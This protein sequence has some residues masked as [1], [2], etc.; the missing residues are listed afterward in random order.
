MVVAVW[1]NLPAGLQT[2]GSFLKI[3][4]RERCFVKLIGEDTEKKKKKEKRWGWGL[5]QMR[6]SNRSRLLISY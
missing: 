3:P 4:T 1:F 2:V 6:V 5:G